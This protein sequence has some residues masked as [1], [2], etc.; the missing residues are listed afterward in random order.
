MVV[1]VLVREEGGVGDGAF[2]EG[3]SCA[4]VICEYVV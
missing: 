3:G 2:E 4:A 1:G